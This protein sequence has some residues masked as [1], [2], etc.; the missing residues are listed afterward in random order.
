MS[1]IE[2]YSTDKP[3]IIWSHIPLNRAAL[4]EVLKIKTR[5]NIIEYAQVQLYQPAEKL[6]VALQQSQINTL[7]I[8]A[9]SGAQQRYD[10]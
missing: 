6:L 3:P 4:D 9:L 10:E 1:E 5:D 7:T 8:L 2:K